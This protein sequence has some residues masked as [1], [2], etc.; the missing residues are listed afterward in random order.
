MAIKYIR[1]NNTDGESTNLRERL[2][3]CTQLIID[4]PTKEFRT[5]N[6]SG[7]TPPSGSDMSHTWG[8]VGGNTTFTP[9]SV[10]SVGTSASLMEITPQQKKSIQSYY[11]NVNTI[12][13]TSESTDNARRYYIPCFKILDDTSGFAGKTSGSMYYHFYGLRTAVGITGHGLG[14]RQV[15]IPFSSSVEGDA[16]NSWYLDPSFGGEESADGTGF[17]WHPNF[18]YPSPLKV[19]ITGSIKNDLDPEVYNI[20][21]SINLVAQD[22]LYSGFRSLGGGANNF[23]QYP[24]NMS[25]PILISASS[26]ND[27]SFKIELELTQSYS[28]IL[29][30]IMGVPYSNRGI[31]TRFDSS[32][33]NYNSGWALALYSNNTHSAGDAANHNQGTSPYYIDSGQITASIEFL[34]RAPSTTYVN[35]INA[36]STPFADELSSSYTPGQ[37]F[38][39]S[40]TEESSSYTGSGDFLVIN[41]AS[42]GLNSNTFLTPNAT[43]LLNTSSM[44]FELPGEFTNRENLPTNGLSDYIIQNNYQ[45]GYITKIPQFVHTAS[46]L[47]QQLLQTESQVIIS[48]GA[49]FD[50]SN[51]PNLNNV[52]EEEPSTKFFV[53]EYNNGVQN[54]SNLRLI[55][56]RSAT[57]AQIEDASYSREVWIS[58]RYKGSRISSND[59]NSIQ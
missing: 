17:S 43:A 10:T 40:I 32:P 28:R 58:S 33:A 52:F 15:G 22:L 6:P 23:S 53:V 9:T 21:S 16:T 38:G 37:T 31:S 54:A 29:D 8:L 5:F 3:Q 30:T 4:I 18:V 25:I 51:S 2:S 14:E 34:Y 44:F 11:P 36:G 49:D 42:L 26:G 35:N 13:T 50:T 41:S 46:A 47:T 27:Q 12:L 45:W 57:P 24:S 19:T 39:F 20:T 56:D 48:P 55:K 7:K 1:I 59:F